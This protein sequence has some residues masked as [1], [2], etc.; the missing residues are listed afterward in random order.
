MRNLFD[1]L[2]K[3][4]NIEI[5]KREFWRDKFK[6]CKVITNTLKLTFRNFIAERDADIDGA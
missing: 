5:L 4:I 3:Y 2:F 1:R 6:V